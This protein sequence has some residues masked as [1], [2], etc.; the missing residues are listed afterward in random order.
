VKPGDSAAP[1]GS[2]LLNPSDRDLTNYRFGQAGVWLR[3]FTIPSDNTVSSNTLPL[4]NLTA[5]RAVS[6][7]IMRR[8]VGSGSSPYTYQL[9]R[10]EVRPFG[11]TAGTK[12]RST[13]TQGYDLFGANGYNDPTD[14]VNGGNA[15]GDA[16]C[17][18]RPNGAF[19]LGNG[20]IDFGVRVW[21]LSK[22]IRD[23]DGDG[24][25][26]EYLL[27]ETF[28]VNRRISDANASIRW[29]FAVTSD[30][31]DTKLQQNTAFTAGN[32]FTADQT[33]YSSAYPNAADR[34]SSA[35]PAVVEVMVR[36]LSPE[37]I[38]IIQ[39]YEEDPSRFGGSSPSK[40]WELAEAN[41]KVYVRRL[42]I[43]AK[44]L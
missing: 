22:D 15:A 9:Y 40:W 42:E 5:P 7:Q 25:L 10:S 37:G 20:V 38:Q 32:N 2:L 14:A 26:T 12:T 3:F 11:T 29:V 36:I 27:Y 44:A 4:S 31:T 24:D 34:D 8:Q 43:R 17:V 33:S 28:P 23:L 21:V 35:Y 1:N 30:V 6:Y 39:S 41:S 18:R 19:V 13:F 16:G